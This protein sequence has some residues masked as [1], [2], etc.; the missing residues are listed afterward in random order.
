MR[1]NRRQFLALGASAA[2]VSRQ[3]LAAGAELDTAYVNGR[4][5]TGVPGAPIRSEEHTSELQSP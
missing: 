1:A 3:L 4:V 5:W 2:L